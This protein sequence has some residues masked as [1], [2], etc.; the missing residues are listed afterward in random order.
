VKPGQVQFEFL[1][2]YLLQAHFQD[3]YPI[4]PTNATAP[5][6]K[7]STRAA[8]PSTN[9]A[10]LTGTS[11]AHKMAQTTGNCTFS[12]LLDCRLIAA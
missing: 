1:F 5:F 8:A 6:T 12:L 2:S 4:A 10:P 7:T 3:N 9:I 11:T